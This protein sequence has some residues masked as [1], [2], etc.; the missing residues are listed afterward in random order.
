[1]DK[2]DFIEGQK[3][4]YDSY[5][6]PRTD[7]LHYIY[8]L[9]LYLSHNFPHKEDNREV[10]K[11]CKEFNLK[12]K[13]VLDVGSYTG[14]KSFYFHAQRNKVMAVDLSI[15]LNN[16]AVKRYRR[17]DIAFH[18]GEINEVLDT[19]I[20]NA[21]IDFIHCNA[22]PLHYD[23]RDV[24]TS[25]Y[26]RHTMLNMLKKLK[27]NGKLYYAFYTIES[28]KIFAPV[29]EQSLLNFLDANNI[30]NYSIR[31]NP[32]NKFGNPLLECI[33]TMTDQYNPANPL[34]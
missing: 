15:T 13:T 32:D 33:I 4:N 21:S 22:I 5:L 28:Q 14:Y 17:Y 11:L 2:G 16:Y 10:R 30:R 8:D 31:I 34:A 19:K 24:A 1:M 9:L 25:P 29:K 18:R 3:L 6:L 27:Q 23:T 7:L 26:F 12:N 20:P